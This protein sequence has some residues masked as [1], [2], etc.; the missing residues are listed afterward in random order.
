MISLQIYL[1]MK[2]MGTLRPEDERKYGVY[3]RLSVVSHSPKVYD[4]LYGRY[5]HA[6]WVLKKSVF[7]VKELW[8]WFTSRYVTVR[9]GTSIVQSLVNSQ[10]SMLYLMRFL[11]FSNEDRFLLFRVS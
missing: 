1:V 10:P 11:C 6:N 5:E 7:F 3:G 2:K 4:V 8:E 9:I